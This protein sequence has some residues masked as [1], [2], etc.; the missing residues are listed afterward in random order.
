MKKLFGFIKDSGLL[1]IVVMLLCS[2]FGVH[3]AMTADTTVVDPVPNTV[4]IPSTNTASPDLL[5]DYIDREIVNIRPYNV[6]LDTISRNVKTVKTSTGQKVKHYF[7]NAQGVSTTVSTQVTSGSVAELNLADGTIVALDDVL[8]C[9]GIPGYLDGT[10]TQDTKHDLQ[11]YVKGKSSGDKPI[12]VAINGSGSTNDTIPTIP[13]GTTILTSGRALTETQ[14][15]TEAYN[16]VP[17]NGLI[18]LQ[19]FGAQIEESELHKLADKE[20]DFKFSDLEEEALYNMRRKQNFQFWKGKQMMKTLKNSRNDTNEEI[21]WTGG[22]W[23]QAEGQYEIGAATTGALTSDDL[24]DLIKYAFTGNESGQ[25]K[26]L[27]M[28][29]LFLQAMEKVDYTKNITVGAQKQEYGLVF[30]SIISKFGTLYGVHSKSFDD[31]GMTDKA[32]ILDADLLVKYTMGWETADIDFKS[33][34]QK[35]VEGRWY[36]EI[37]G[38]ALK[39][40]AAHARVSLNTFAAA[41]TE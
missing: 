28:G 21:F 9:L 10:S 35:S 7:I 41:A 38:L 2:L 40:P 27:I 5:L 1:M 17:T 33:N 34:G 30:N 25:R 12:V 36:H 14:I 29:S 16:K 37:C 4:T 3:G 26:L 11:L 32:F 20:V 8:I 39:N 31:M 24:V 15:Q 19:K 23:G 18:Y 6:E 13:A 22:I